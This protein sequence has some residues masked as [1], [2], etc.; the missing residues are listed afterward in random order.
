MAAPGI[1]FIIADMAS[2]PSVRIMGTHKPITSPWAA[3]YLLF[4]CFGSRRPMGAR[5]L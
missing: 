2:R 4:S 1:G 3:A 5:T